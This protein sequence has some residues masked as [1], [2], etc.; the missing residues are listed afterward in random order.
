MGGGPPPYGQ[1]PLAGIASNSVNPF[2]GVAAQPFMGPG[3]HAGG[4]AAADGALLLLQHIQSC[5][6]LRHSPPLGHCLP[7]RTC[8]LE[9][10]ACTG[11]PRPHLPVMT[12]QNAT[13][14]S[15]IATMQQARRK[16]ARCAAIVKQ[17]NCP[18]ATRHRGVRGASGQ[19]PRRRRQ[20]RSLGQSGARTVGRVRLQPAHV[21]QHSHEDRQHGQPGVPAAAAGIRVLRA[22]ARQCGCCRRRRPWCA[23]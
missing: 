5:A 12:D 11:I 18:C 22:A 21:Y 20:P 8:M 4:D 7:P 19:L 17:H 9:R 6:Q 3:G 1:A 23:F 14:R 15:S 2:E 10:D 13:S 16:E